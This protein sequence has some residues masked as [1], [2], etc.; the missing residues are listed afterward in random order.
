M[1]FVQQVNSI[2]N[3]RTFKMIQSLVVAS[4][5]VFLFGCSSKIEKEIVGKWEKTSGSEAETIEFKSDGSFNGLHGLIFSIN[6]SYKFLNK[7]KLQLI[8]PNGSPLGDAS[9][10]A[11]SDDG[12][13]LTWTFTNGGQQVTYKRIDKQ[14]SANA[15]QGTAQAEPKNMADL[16]QSMQPSSS[17][18]KPKLSAAAER[19]VSEGFV[20]I[21]DPA[22]K[23]CTEKKVGDIKKQIGPDAVIN[24]ETYNEAA[25]NCGFNI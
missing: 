6:G 11:I 20:E 4:C 25:V 16:R 7:N 19:A 23:E 22:V 10:V 2:R 1:S 21:Q 14:S 18:E 8:S 24:F 5:V 17:L 9:E 3:F 15:E 13:T 12:Q